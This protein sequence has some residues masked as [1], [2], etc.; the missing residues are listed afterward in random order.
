MI[1]FLRGKVI[2]KRPT[3]LV[4]DVRG[5]GYEVNIPL[6]TFKHI[7]E[8]GQDTTVLT[9]LWVKN[10][11][12]ELYGFAT[13]AER[14]MFSALVS[15]SG[16]G[17]KSAIKILSG[18]TAEELRSAVAEGDSFFL[19]S[20][21]GVG[22]KTAERVIVELRDRFASYQPERVPVLPQRNRE[23]LTALISL[24]FRRRAAEESVERVVKSNPDIT[25]EDL[26]REALKAL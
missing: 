24:G 20:I 8:P 9:H 19:S 7:P 2:E 25:L 17:A 15:V 10:E 16:I 12:M 3:Q 23:A 18:T 14:E 13:E 1:S 11:R 5:V 22:K 26:V 6:S 4:L 21:H